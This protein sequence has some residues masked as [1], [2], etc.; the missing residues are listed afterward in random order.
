MPGCSLTPLGLTAGGEAIQ[1]ADSTGVYGIS[2]LIVM[3]NQ[4]LSQIPDLLITRRLAPTLTAGQA[5]GINWTAHLSTLALVLAL[6]FSY[7]WYKMV[8]PQGG[9]HLRALT[10]LSDY[11]DRTAPPPSAL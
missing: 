1:I 4:V 7:G 6:T 10:W 5:G 2:F 3:V 9:E 11:L 8:A